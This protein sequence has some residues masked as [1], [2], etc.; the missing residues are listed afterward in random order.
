VTRFVV[1]A[2][3]ALKWYLPEP[4]DDHAARLQHSGAAI[5]AP[6]LLFAE[7]GNSLWKRV[8]RGELTTAEAGRI[9]AAISRLPIETY[10]CRLL[11]G[12]ALQ[13]GC[14]AGVTVYDALYLATALLTDGRVVTADRRLYEAA[15]RVTPLR[16]RL[17][18]I[19]D[20]PA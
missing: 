4:D 20:I 3:V 5:D 17:I 15:R 18:W 11:A 2:S 19:A 8:R 9:Q 16:D 12:A 7:V 6:D 10:P 13:I 1:D 14:A